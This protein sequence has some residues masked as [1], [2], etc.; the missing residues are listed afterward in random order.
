MEI[1]QH[2][3]DNHMDMCRFSTASD[4][5]Y[6]KV[7][8]AIEWILA[9]VSHNS[10]EADETKL[11]DAERQIYID[12]LRFDQLDARLVT[13]KSAPAKTCK[14]L[15]ENPGYLKWLAPEQRKEHN[16]FLWI[17]GKAGS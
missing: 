7:A 1:T 15:L 9:N 6:L 5:E 14:S 12:S 10:S 3:A 2:L 4:T 13:I 8:A 17:K 16:G 11:G